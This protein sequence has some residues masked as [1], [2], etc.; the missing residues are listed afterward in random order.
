MHL[1]RK[2]LA[3]DAMLARGVKMELHQPVSGVA[4]FQHAAVPA[5]QLDGVAGVDD[6][7]GALVPYDLE[8][9][10]LRADRIADVDRR[11][12]RA[13]RAGTIRGIEVAPFGRAVCPFIAPVGVSS[14]T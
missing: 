4:V 14:K 13:D 8:R 10:E 5:I 7:V 9:V 1:H 12:L 6:G 11:L 2:L 3:G